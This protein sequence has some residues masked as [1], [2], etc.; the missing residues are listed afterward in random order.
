MI[1]LKFS[2]ILII[3]VL[4]SI[5]SNLVEA[6]L[7]LQKQNVIPVVLSISLVDISIYNITLRCL[8][9]KKILQLQVGYSVWECLQ[10]LCPS[11]KMVDLTHLPLSYS[12]GILQTLWNRGSIRHINI[13]LR[14]SSTTRH[15]GL[16]I[17][18]TV[19]IIIVYL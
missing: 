4:L 11:K 14:F 16:L 19:G 8:F 2:F 18:V 17:R 6:L 9:I 10:D 7:K 5:R 15:T 1:F 13:Y 12:T 3:K